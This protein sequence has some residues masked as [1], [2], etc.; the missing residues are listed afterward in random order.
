[1]SKQS[2]DGMNQAG[3]NNAVGKS[4]RALPK[5][6]TEMLPKDNGS[7]NNAFQPKITET[8]RNRD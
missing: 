2:T 4:A 5:R 7:D 1:M 8:K 6:G 3:G